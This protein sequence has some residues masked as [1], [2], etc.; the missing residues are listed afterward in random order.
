MNRFWVDSAVLTA[1]SGSCYVEVYDKYPD[2]NTAV[3]LKANYISEAGDTLAQ[4]C[5]LLPLEEWD[6]VISCKLGQFWSCTQIVA[7]WDIDNDPKTGAR[8][9][10]DPR[11]RVRSKL[12]NLRCYIFPDDPHE[13]RKQLVIVRRS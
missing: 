5:A 12:A 4:L 9:Y 6:E 11:T 7:P 8:A 3:L 10:P 13:A 2:D 1:A